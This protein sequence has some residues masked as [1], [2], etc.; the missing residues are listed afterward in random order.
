M[1]KILIVTTSFPSLLRENK[2]IGGGAFIL[3]EVEALISASYTVKII[4]PAINGLSSFESCPG[5]ELERVAYPLQ[6]Y[7]PG[8]NKRPQHGDLKLINKVS[9][10][11][12]ALALLKV[13]YAELKKSSYQIVWSNWLQVGMICSL[14]N[15]RHVPHLMSIR[16]SDVRES[17]KAMVKF[18]A[19]FCPNLLNMYSDD[20]ALNHWI[21]EFGFVNHI[22][23]G[24]Y[25]EKSLAR[26]EPARPL[27]AIVGRLDGEASGLHM[28]GLGSNLFEAIKQLF[29]KRSDF[30]VIVIGD[31]KQLNDLQ[32]LLSEF[33]G[34][35]TFTGWLG[36]FDQYLAKATLVI[37]GGG[38]N[39]VVM[40][41]TP[42]GIPLM[43]SKYLTGS[44]WV[45]KQ[46]CLVFDPYDINNIS[47]TIEYAI[48]NPQQLEGFGQK[49]QIDLTKFALPTDK[50][51]IVWR[52]IFEKFCS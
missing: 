23:P 46:N 35:V 17:K 19:K 1:K 42:Y 3:K 32:C 6:H 2:G 20:E 48:E 11:S 40:D 50:A 36:E 44:I 13:I 31:G 4:M 22:V 52:E 45:D 9:Q 29:Q 27:I 16:G 49:A 24:V 43:I 37:G 47:R 38:T 41:T 7:N 28:K 12:M 26:V 30:D 15:R 14:A 10:V 25:T 34:N 21:E 51:G 33:T 18:M 39:G 5:I 8:F